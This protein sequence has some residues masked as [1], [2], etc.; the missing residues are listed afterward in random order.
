M[1]RQLKMPKSR[2][3]GRHAPL[4]AG[5]TSRSPSVIV[6]LAAYRPAGA[7]A[8]THVIQ[9]SPLLPLAADVTSLIESALCTSRSRFRQAATVACTHS[10]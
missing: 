4:E 7:P 2:Q 5:A 8:C 10:N 1:H 3:A 6:P 9:V